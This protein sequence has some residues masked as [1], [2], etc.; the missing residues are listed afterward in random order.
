MS[1][2]KVTH[3]YYPSIN[4]EGVQGMKGPKGLKGIRGPQGYSGPP[5]PPGPP[6]PK[7]DFGDRGLKGSSGIKGDPGPIGLTGND[8]PPG[9]Q[10]SKG[11]EGFSGD[12]IDYY[13][14]NSDNKLVIVYVG[15]TQSLP[16]DGLTGEKGESGTAGS[17]GS[18]GTNG[19]KG[20]TGI[21]G[22]QGNSGSQGF[23]GNNG[24][25]IT[26][27]THVNNNF[28][29]ELSDTNN[30]SLSIPSKGD[31]GS[32]GDKGDSGNDA[33]EENLTIYKG[34]LGFYSDFFSTAYALEKVKDRFYLQPM[35]ELKYK[36]LDNGNI[37]YT[38]PTN[39]NKLRN[40]N[41]NNHD[42]F[43]TGLY[44]PM[45]GPPFLEKFAGSLLSV[46]DFDPFNPSTETFSTGHKIIANGLNITHDSI[47]KSF[48]INIKSLIKNTDKGIIQTSTGSLN[49]TGNINTIA[50]FNKYFYGNVSIDD[51]GTIENYYIPI[52]VFIRFEI[53]TPNISNNSFDFWYIS[54]PIPNPPIYILDPNGTTENN[55]SAA[56]TLRS[57]T[58][59]IGIQDNSTYD[60]P[61]DVVYP[62]GPAW[63]VRTDHPSYVATDPRNKL[64]TGD[65]LC[66][67]LS[68]SRPDFDYND[69]TFDGSPTSPPADFFDSTLC[70]QCEDIRN[71][72]Q[73][74]ISDN[75]SNLSSIVTLEKT[76]V[77]IIENV[78]D[79]I[80]GIYVPDL[81]FANIDVNEIDVSIELDKF[82]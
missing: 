17:K 28:L 15:G 79:N 48:K 71:I 5:G 12:I 51:L 66:I 38:L 34:N 61:Q 35:S 6:G 27:V 21:T 76:Y 2:N 63:T 23:I 82:N 31:E 14:V 69:Y 68:F 46:E 64:N 59:W 57:H 70:S 26:N 60:I 54:D 16:I 52:K 73:N 11:D 40:V 24:V 53:H 20:D 30:I 41:F 36:T 75:I 55:F 18:S 67:R 45:G 25:G 50:D 62:S 7:G 32:K 8:G 19:T 13:Y 9:P 65:K 42:Q 39:T 10:G 43:Y 74:L 81:L 77:D 72:Y 22:P 47:A 80:A 4:K 44:S 49:Y 1:S 3:I 37:S 58:G 33:I 29:F 78:S 56:F